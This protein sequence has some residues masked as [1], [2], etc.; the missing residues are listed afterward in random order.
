MAYNL[1]PPW[2]PKYA[3]PANTRVEALQRGTFTTRQQPRG[4]Y[5]DPAVGDG[6]YAVPDYV[7]AQPYGQG[8]H[9]TKWMPRGTVVGR[10]PHWVQQ[11]NFAILA[12]TKAS[13]D[14]TGYEIGPP[15]ESVHTDPFQSYGARVADQVMLHLRR[16]PPPQRKPAL[17]A[18]FRRIDPK[19]YSRVYATATTAVRAGIPPQRALHTAIAKEMRGGFLR[20]LHSVGMTGHVKVGSQTGLGCWG[21]AALG[22]D[23]GATPPVKQ[24]AQVNATPGVPIVVN[25]VHNADGSYSEYCTQGTAIVPCPGGGQLATTPNSGVAN[26]MGPAGGGT[27]TLGPFQFTIGGGAV[28]HRN[29]FTDPS[30]LTAAQAAWIQ[31][32][33]KSVG[34][35]MVPDDGRLDLQT[36]FGVKGARVNKDWNSSDGVA[37]PV[38][39]IYGPFADPSNPAGEKYGIFLYIC[40][41][42]CSGWPH[43]P[44]LALVAAPMSKAS[45]TSTSMAG[46]A[47]G[48]FIK[49]VGGAIGS[50][51]CDVLG[52]QGAPSAA[53]LAAGGPAATGVG[54]ASALCA[55]N[56]AQPMVGPPPLIGKG[57]ETL[58]IAGG[59][60]A[61]L[62]YLIRKRR[63]GG[64]AARSSRRTSR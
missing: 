32:Q 47:I 45:F 11:P 37:M 57:T 31:Q 8:A 64:A 19:L 6:G 21:C 34:A 48:G 44:Y 56:T 30:Q 58:L 28:D 23:L 25:R 16:L 39:P 53:K 41:S 49:S 63:Q 51:A 54:I 55:S 61:L 18:L 42:K 38:N 52:H 12:Q 10:V 59:G 29:A 9:V 2:S 62:Y 1:P 14:G 7:L 22:D 26:P 46:T 43:T 17:K 20:E 4:S 36:W 3:Y 50:I 15:I 13:G 24:V 33:L 5:D 27:I 60:V 35:V 40:G